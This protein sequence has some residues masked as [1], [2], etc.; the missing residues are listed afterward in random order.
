MALTAAA[1]ELQIGGTKKS[2]RILTRGVG[3]RH[4]TRGRG[5]TPGTLLG[6]APAQIFPQRGLQPLLAAA[7]MAGF[8]GF[9]VVLGPVHHGLIIAGAAPQASSSIALLFGW[10][11][12][13]FPPRSRRPPLAARYL[14][15]P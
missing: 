1:S 6:L 8:T 13:Q 9:V 4:S 3:R 12:W 5:G 7:G 15:L 11:L 10:R 14:K 2:V